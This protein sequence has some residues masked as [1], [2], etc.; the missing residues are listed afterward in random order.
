MNTLMSG[1]PIGYWLNVCMYTL[2]RGGMYVC[3]YL[4]VCI[5][6]KENI[7]VVT[8]L[9]GGSGCLPA[10]CS[11]LSERFPLAISTHPALYSNLK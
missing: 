7:S 9:L 10:I 4:C 6:E 5:C 1:G 8:N 3:M 2:M 11:C